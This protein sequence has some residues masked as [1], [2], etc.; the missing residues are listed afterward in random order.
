MRLAN[1]SETHEE[2]GLTHAVQP[3]AVARIECA[4]RSF[5]GRPD[6]DDPVFNA[7]PKKRDP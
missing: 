5:D 1:V 3:T 7:R 2:A 6:S 4:Q